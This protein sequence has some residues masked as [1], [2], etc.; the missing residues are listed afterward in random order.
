MTSCA[1]SPA[2]SPSLLTDLYRG[3][4]R[5]DLLTPFPEQ[6]PADRQAADVALE[7][8]E[9]L[10]TERIDPERVDREGLLPN[11]FL[12]ALTD[13]GLMALTTDP[14]LG[15]LGLS[16]RN[17]VRVIERAARH[18]VPV[19]FAMAICNGF[20]SGTY[21]PALPA[22]PL[23][24]MIER[25]VAVGLVSAGADAEAI[26]TA[27]Q[28]R[29]TTAV[30]VDGGAAY[31]LTGEKVYIGN[32]GVA[33]LMDV[34]AT[35]VDADGTEQVRLFFVDTT[36][37]GFSAT[38]RHEF[39]GLRGAEI[40]SLRLDRARV[41]A[42]YMLVEGAGDWRMRP[43]PV[44]GVEPDPAVPDAP[45][46]DLGWLATVGRTLV[47]APAALALAR[48]CLDWSRDFAATRRIDGRPLDDY[49][50]IRRQ[51]AA[52]AADVFTID[53]VTTWGLLG[54]DRADTLP[55]LTA[56]KNIAS[57]SCW[58]VVDRTMSLF[59]AQGYETAA[60]KARR[61]VP[62]VPVERAFRDARALRVAGGVDFMLD[63]WSAR[64]ALDAAHPAGAPGSPDTGDTGP[65]GLAAHPR[66]AEHRR[67]VDSQAAELGAVC[68]RLTRNYTREELFGR[69]RTLIVL[70][71][72]GR[73]LL[74]MAVV[75]ARAAG[76][77]TRGETSALQLADIAC[78][79]ARHRLAG[80]WPQLADE[81]DIPADD[82]L[83]MP[84]TGVLSHA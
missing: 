50:E 67:F 6:D 65:A 77:A 13:A 61:G 72:I 10:L 30:P 2:G 41:P 63:L 75:L 53:S 18:S 39:M 4:V 12:A 22:G 40:W 15:G 3:R 83:T 45:T 46:A 57:L 68:R 23:R 29:G 66:C 11:G 81:P 71:R 33:D 84:T 31:L 32:G 28:R 78:T 26:G 24:D 14:A 76:L 62:A 70:G 48:S 69:Q 38:C 16:H 64:S 52:T 82:I 44:D 47:I 80:L 8:L 35:V 5:W 25:R 37:P 74:S 56:T 20:G 19:A 55:D 79:A 49:D 59:G 27:N 17:A 73:E 36:G 58:A 1:S 9:R 54:R 34:S 7:A 21:L 51:L 43:G 60:S 42:E